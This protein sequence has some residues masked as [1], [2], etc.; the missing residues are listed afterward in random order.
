MDN[1]S[2][3]PVFGSKPPP[4]TAAVGP[5]RTES[6][7]TAARAFEAA[8]LAEMF[9]HAGLAAARSGENG[10]GGGVGGGGVG[11]DAFSSFLSRA[12]AEKVAERGGVGL[13]ERLFQALAQRAADDV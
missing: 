6:L 13:S 1:L 3:M 2:A 7:R 12:W 8:F 11:E 10:F 4:A 9:A 5:D